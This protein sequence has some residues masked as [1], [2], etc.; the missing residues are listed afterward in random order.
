MAT[1]GGG[2]DRPGRVPGRHI[3]AGLLTAGEYS[4]DWGI[5]VGAPLRRQWGGVRVS[6]ME[7]LTLNALQNQ[8]T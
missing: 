1:C 8:A 5:D 3:Q 2:R 4:A 6:G 7:R